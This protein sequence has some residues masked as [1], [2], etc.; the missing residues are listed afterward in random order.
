MAQM[1]VEGTF[2]AIVDAEWGIM[3]SG[4]IDA[5]TGRFTVVEIPKHD[6]ERAEMREAVFEDAAD[7]G[8]FD[9]I[10]SGWYFAVESDSDTWTF[11]RCKNRDYALARFALARAA[12]EDWEDLQLG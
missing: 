4:A 7:A 9:G 10:E 2:K 12:Y 8:I 5:P 1:T 11:E 6:G 3:S